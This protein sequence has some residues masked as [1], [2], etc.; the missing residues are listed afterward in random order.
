MGLKAIT[1]EDYDRLVE[2]FREHGT[3]SMKLVAKA[4]KVHWNTANRGWNEGWPNKNLAPIKDLILREH[5]MTRKIREEQ[6]KNQL[7][8]E[9]ADTLV[10]EAEV[11]AKAIIDKAEQDARKKMADLLERSGHDAAEQRADE[12]MLSRLARKNVISAQAFISAAWQNARALANE[13]TRAVQAGEITAAQAMR[14]A[15]KLMRGTQVVNDAA[16][17]SMQVERIRVGEPTE[18]ISV[19]LEP[20]N[21]EEAA[22]DIEH[23]A[24]LVAMARQRGLIDDPVIEPE[25]GEDNGQGGALN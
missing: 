1:K 22:R 9:R 23:A 10:V 11:R 8:N 12:A 25:D 13:V 24:A 6:V 16:K 19:K 18:T 4:A 2:A 20:A 14:F 3:T 15:E 21:L 5:A 17:L 7:S